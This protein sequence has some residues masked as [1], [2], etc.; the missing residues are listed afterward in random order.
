M[1]QQC[2]DDDS[3]AARQ[4]AVLLPWHEPAAAGLAG[5]KDSLPPSSS[6]VPQPLCW[7]YEELE[8]DQ[9]CHAPWLQIKVLINVWDMY[10]ILNLAEGTLIVEQDNL[11]P[12]RWT[13]K[14]SNSVPV[15]EVPGGHLIGPILE[16]LLQQHDT[17]CTVGKP[18]PCNVGK[19]STE[20]S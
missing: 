2:R 11:C 3:R 17:L 7:G 15:G 4:A 6:R 8:R 10:K 9:V 12:G 18:C 16:I 14:K 13:L 1:C 19:D 5:G 20:H